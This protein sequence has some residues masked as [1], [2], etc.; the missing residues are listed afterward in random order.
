MAADHLDPVLVRLRLSA[1]ADADFFFFA[2]ADLAAVT[3]MRRQYTCTPELHFCCASYS[4]C[5]TEQTD[6][7]MAST[8]V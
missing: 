4:A 6:L 1:P 3:V 7:P 8:A 5:I 2:L